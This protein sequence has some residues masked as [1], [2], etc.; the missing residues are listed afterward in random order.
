M[1]LK[2][3]LPKW[4]SL[5]RG[6]LDSKQFLTAGVAGIFRP[7]NSLILCCFGKPRSSL[8]LRERPGS[9]FHSMIRL[10]P[11]VSWLLLMPEG[12][13]LDQALLQYGPHEISSFFPAC[14]Q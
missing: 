12:D 10:H 6:I 7:E 11:F 14:L 9:I 2:P 4:K 13:C 1:M 8:I 3:S 5:V